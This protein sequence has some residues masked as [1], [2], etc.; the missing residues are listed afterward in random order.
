MTISLRRDRDVRCN[1]PVSGREGMKKKRSIKKGIKSISAS[2]IM[3]LVDMKATFWVVSP[4]C[5]TSPPQRRNNLGGFFSPR[6]GPTHRG[7]SRDYSGVSSRGSCHVRQRRR[8]LLWGRL[9]NATRWSDGAVFIWKE[10]RLGAAGRHLSA[11]YH[12]L[13]EPLRRTNLSISTLVIFHKT[14]CL[15]FDSILCLCIVFDLTLLETQ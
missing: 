5:S 14:R 12:P 2:L 13:H 9:A 15:L 6:V 4:S 10:Q 8:R 1:L 7:A 11:E 3:A